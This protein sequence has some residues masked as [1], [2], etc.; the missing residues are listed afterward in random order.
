MNYGIVGIQ[1]KKQF[2]DAKELEKRGAFLTREE[3]EK[4]AKKIIATRA[5]QERNPAMMQLQNNEDAIANIVTILAWADW[6]YD[7]TKGLTRYQ[8]RRQR[9]YHAILEFLR[10]EKAKKKM[11]FAPLPDSNVVSDNDE[12]DND[13]LNYLIEI[14]ELSE[15][16]KV[17]LKM[18]AHGYSYRDM[19]ASLGMNHQQQSAQYLASAKKKIARKMEELDL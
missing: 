11:N 18:K 14:C 10:L 15:R 13:H 16:E 9:G 1:T 8:Y 3:Y 6:D 17:C 5:S 12:I 2:P 7:P 4:I 19:A